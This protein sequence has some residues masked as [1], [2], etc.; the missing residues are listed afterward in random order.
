MFIIQINNFDLTMNE[1]MVIFCFNIKTMLL[2][3]QFFFKNFFYYI[4]YYSSI[5]SCPCYQLT[6][7]KNDWIENGTEPLSHFQN[8]NTWEFLLHVC[9]IQNVYRMLLFEI[10]KN[11]RHLMSVDNR[12]D[13]G[14]ELVKN[15]GFWC[16]VIWN[17]VE[18]VQ[19]KKFL[20]TM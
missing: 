15:G 12:L 19:P 13:H 3:C 7:F 14:G 2:F 1:A 20:K 18:A 10:L 16:S 5:N 6:L 17:H 11:A 4:E 9:I 8:S